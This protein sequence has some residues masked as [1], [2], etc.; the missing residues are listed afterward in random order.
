MN[1]TALR[2]LVILLIAA[3]ALNAALAAAVSGESGE[4]FTPLPAE[5]VDVF[6]QVLMEDGRIAVATMD[7]QLLVRENDQEIASTQ[8]ETAVGAMLYDKAT[9][10]LIVGCFDGI[11]YYYDPDLTPIAQI[12][13]ERG[14]VV[15]MDTTADGQLVVGTGIGRYGERFYVHLVGRDQTLVATHK[16]GNTVMS[17]GSLGPLLLAGDESA[18]II[19]LTMEGE[20]VWRTQVERLVTV[21]RGVEGD[22]E[23]FAGDAVGNI[24]R[25]DDMGQ[26]VL[27]RNV[28]QYEITEI[29]PVG[30]NLVVGDID[31]GFFLLDQHYDVVRSDTTEKDPATSLYQAEDGSVVGVRRS[32]QRV[33]INVAA[34]ERAKVVNILRPIWYAADAALFIA[35][36]T[37]LVAG[38]ETWRKKAIYVAREL[39]TS[40][41]AYLF[42]LPA[43]ILV[44]CFSYLPT[45][46]AVYYSLTN[47]VPGYPIRFV[48]LRNFIFIFAKDKY[49]WV[50]MGNVLMLLVTGIM[51][52]LT[53]P[54]LVALLIYWYKNERWQYVFRTGFIIPSV[55]PGIVAT[56][57]WKM[58]YDPY[59]GFFN[60]LLKVFGMEHLQRAWLGDPKTA[61]GAIIFAG[62]PWIG[63]FAFLI[64]LGGL[65]NINPEL[66]DAAAIDGANWWTRLR[67]IEWPLLKPQ[68][69]ILLFFTYVGAI[70]GY[71][72]ILVYTRGGPGHATWVPALQLYI[73]LSENMNIGYASAIG[74][75]LFVI[76]F[77]VTIVN[78]SVQRRG[79]VEVLQ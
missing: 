54:L 20:D 19:A 30:E 45:V 41:Q 55:V 70:Q 56:L 43:T 27:E 48:G 60:R 65:I 13:L 37:T 50:G 16:I 52:V 47:Y 33:G 51:K 63:A 38:I 58:M 39:R 62:F 72:S 61:L 17:V 46:L 66:F 2:W 6:A 28:S 49:F 59:G 77:T 4:V 7:S 22:Q 12:D 15:D 31:G 25:L 53:V 78:R 18:W 23:L 35:I 69:N 26:V 5:P 42:V 8:F 9:H 64:Y 73:R 29:V 57:M 68:R 74:F 79:T 1:K 75:L 44:L 32:G 11:V 24:Y 14:R 10:Q 21:I 71:A 40:R 36:L 76:V 67:H 3:L 34:L